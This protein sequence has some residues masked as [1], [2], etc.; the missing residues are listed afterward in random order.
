MR[1]E[2]VDMAETPES[3]ETL[4]GAPFTS[5]RVGVE[6]PAMAGREE[7][8]VP[9]RGFVVMGELVTL[10]LAFGSEGEAANLMASKPLA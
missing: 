2:L 3:T 1:V 6:D 4:R 7:I 10:R 9:A 5:G 8:V